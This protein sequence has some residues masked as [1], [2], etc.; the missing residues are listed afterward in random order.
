[1]QEKKLKLKKLKASK[2]RPCTMAEL[3][4]KVN[5]VNLKARIFVTRKALRGQNRETKNQKE[6]LK[7]NKS[8]FKLNKLILYVYLNSFHL[9]FSIV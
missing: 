6:K 5:G 8:R 9:F 7:E 2:C 4:L 3:G 1:M